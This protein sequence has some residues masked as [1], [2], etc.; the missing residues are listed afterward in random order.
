MH[1][2]SISSG[3]HLIEQYIRTNGINDNGSALYTDG[4]SINAYT[5]KVA[6]RK[7]LYRCG[8]DYIYVKEE[9][10]NIVAVI[11]VDNT[12]AA[13]AA[14]SGETIMFI[15]DT[16]SGVGGKSGKG[17]Q[18]QRRYERNRERELLE[19]YNRVAAKAK[20]LVD[21]KPTKLVI[22]GPA[23]TKTNVYALLDYRLRNLP[24][25]YVDIEYSGHT[26]VYQTI[27]KMKEKG[28]SYRA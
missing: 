19:Y 15:E 20:G 10:D 9:L 23:L 28:T 2:E 24:V 11:S 12:E 18:S 8:A 6:I 27:N 4:T 5:P 3:L 21:L 1:R 26:G 25:E 16:Q 13:V 14:V 22:S 17:G 7:Q